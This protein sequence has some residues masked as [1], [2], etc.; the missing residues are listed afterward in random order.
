MS[1][2]AT[3]RLQSPH[4][5]PSPKKFKADEEAA[6]KTEAS[7]CAASL[8][9]SPSVSLKSSKS[10]GT[11]ET[12]N[13]RDDLV[14]S[15]TFNCILFCW[16]RQLGTNQKTICPFLPSQDPSVV[17]LLDMPIRPNKPAVFVKHSIKLQLLRCSKES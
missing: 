3:N 16:H 4:P 5:E 8:S 17:E 1:Q 13:K 9:A 12:P 2:Q 6:V 10:P 14:C 11:P 15:M 7:C